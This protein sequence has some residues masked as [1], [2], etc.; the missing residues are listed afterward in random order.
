M[1][2]KNTGTANGQLAA[3]E[4]KRQGET[5]PAGQLRQR[6]SATA[7]EDAAPS[8]PQHQTEIQTTMRETIFDLME[9][10][11]TIES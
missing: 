1:I 4:A 9:R 11:R 3:Q 7:T 5:P 2:A 8:E 6:A 10:T